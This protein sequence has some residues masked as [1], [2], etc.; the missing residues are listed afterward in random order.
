MKSLA[1]LM[2]AIVDSKWPI[3]IDWITPGY[4]IF[5]YVN[6]IISIFFQI[7]LNWLEREGVLTQQPFEYIGES[8]E[9][10]GMRSLCPFQLLIPDCMFDF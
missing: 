5:I 8:C 7:Y 9:Y 6:F 2:D 3:A 4:I 10:L 1:V